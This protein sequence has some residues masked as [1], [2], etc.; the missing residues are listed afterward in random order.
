MHT[1]E[2]SDEQALQLWEQLPEIQKKRILAKVV[3]NGKKSI[4]QPR[5]AG[6]G[7]SGILY[8]APDFYEPVEGFEDYQ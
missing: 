7:K 1:I 5:K 4:N 2:L 8:I 3:Q 6:S